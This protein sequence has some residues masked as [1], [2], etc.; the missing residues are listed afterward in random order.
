[1]DRV[2][3]FFSQKHVEKGVLEEVSVETKE[4]G[5][6]FVIGHVFESGVVGGGEGGV[7]HCNE[8]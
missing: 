6:D 2:W 7:G 1:M 5:S 8:G 4:V 3:S